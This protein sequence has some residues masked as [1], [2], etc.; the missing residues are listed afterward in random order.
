V[1]GVSAN[2]PLE[3]RQKRLQ[4]FM[5]FSHEIEDTRSG[6][7]DQ[8][9]EIDLSDAS[10]L[11]ATIDGLPDSAAD[12][13]WLKTEGPI[14]VHFGDTD[15]GGKYGTLLD[16]VQQWRAAAGHIESVDLRFSREA[17]VNPQIPPTQAVAQITAPPVEPLAEGA[18]Q[19]RTRRSASPAST[20]KR[21]AARH[22]R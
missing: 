18:S 11:V 8:V 22:S 17:V 10:D 6:A 2:M 12:T 7:M 5:V 16:D 20:A 14:E 4:M 3:E 13:S 9:S 19:Q 21:R 15:F 1:T